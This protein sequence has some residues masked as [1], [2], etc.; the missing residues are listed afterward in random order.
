MFVYIDYKTAVNFTA[1]GCWSLIKKSQNRCKK[2]Y[3]NQEKNR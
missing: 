1:D 2:D 3:C